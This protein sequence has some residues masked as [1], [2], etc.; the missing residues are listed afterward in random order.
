MIPS[1]GVLAS[2][3][4]RYEKVV[5]RDHQTI[6]SIQYLGALYL[7]S[8]SVYLYIS[9][10]EVFHNASL[11]NY[12]RNFGNLSIFDQDLPGSNWGVHF[13]TGAVV[14]EFYRARNYSKEGAFFMT[15]AQECLFQFTVES[16]FQPTG[17]ENVVYT[18]IVGP[19]IGRG[20]E[21]VSLPLLN[22]EF[23]P[24]RFLGNLLNLPAFFGLW[25]NTTNI[26]PVVNNKAVGLQLQVKF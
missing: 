1:A 14:Y 10:N 19:I 13:I 11:Q 16:M 20:L 21:A 17:L 22:S 15:L 8:T 7:I 2:G 12:A 24:F 25:E 23:L 4:P 9:R 26:A 5:P 6:E 18:G 3:R